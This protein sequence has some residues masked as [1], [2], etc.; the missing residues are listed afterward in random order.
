V[1]VISDYLPPQISRREEYERIFELERKLGIR[2]EFAAVARYIQ[3]IA[4][5]SCASSSKDTG[6]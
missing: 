1:R 3:V 2:P 4:R 6:P 5:Q